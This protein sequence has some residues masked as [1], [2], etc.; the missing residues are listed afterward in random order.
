LALAFFDLLSFVGRVPLGA[1]F[2]QGGRFDARF[3]VMQ[4]G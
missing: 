3:V 2:L 1:G 4:P